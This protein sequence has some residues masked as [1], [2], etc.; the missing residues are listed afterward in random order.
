MGGLNHDFLLLSRNEHPFSYWNLFYHRPDAVLIHHDLLEYI[1]DSLK[2]IPTYN[3]AA[4]HP[5]RGLCWFGPTIIKEDGAEITRNVFTLWA[6]LFAHG[7]SVLKLQGPFGWEVD[8][9]LEKDGYEKVIPG[10][11]KNN[12]LIVNRNEFIKKLKT[13][14]G[15]ADQVLQSDGDL[16]IL[17]IGI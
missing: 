7:P 14:A 16:Y 11:A 9:D 1:G 15:Y 5:D 3:P 13:I 2:W 4:H 12:R 10:S 8:N 6:E 17:H